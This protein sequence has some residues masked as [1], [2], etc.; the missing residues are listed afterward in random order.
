MCKSTVS[1]LLD[2]ESKKNSDFSPVL[3]FVYIRP[4]HTKKTINALLKNPESKNTDLIVYADAPRC[5]RD[6][7]LAED[8]LSIVYNIQGFKSLTVNVRDKNFGLAKNIIDGV[9]EVIKMYGRVIVLEDD[10][11][12]SSG[13]LKFMN[14]ALVRYKEH[15]NVW[16]ISGWN[17]PVCSGDSL[18]S[19]YFW[20]TMNCWGWA[21]WSDR[22]FHFNKDPKDLI[23][24]WSS[25]DIY[26]F[27]LD[28]VHD[29]WVQVL[30]NYNNRMNTWA[31]F[32]YATIFSHKGLCLN[33]IHSLVANIGHDGTGENCGSDDVYG[34][35]MANFFD[36]KWPKNI[37]ENEYIVN[38]NKQ[39][40]HSI[41]L[42]LFGRILRKLKR[43]IA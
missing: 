17:Y 29:F 24:N 42:S 5:E 18:P 43:A 6:K 33:P 40:Y 31:V 4:E 34:S 32:W 28:G 15:K 3:L 7:I 22:W 12:T 37:E 20:R 41:K 23:D 9:S 30:G 36:G 10:I 14:D 8:V 39:F 35:E 38:L 26:K 16:H 11:V 21:T 27:N 13:F 1:S 25:N 2:S 19:A